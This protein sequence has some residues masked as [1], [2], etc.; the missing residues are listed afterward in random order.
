MHTDMSVRGN[1]RQMKQ[2]LRKRFNFPDHFKPVLQR[3]PLADLI[4]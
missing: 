2:G 4:S 1:R 3:T